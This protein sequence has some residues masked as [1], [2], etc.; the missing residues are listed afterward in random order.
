MNT[1]QWIQIILSGSMV[2]V[3]IILAI[4]TGVLALITYGYMKATKKMAESMRIQSKIMQ[5]EFELK[6]APIFEPKISVGSTQGLKSEIKVRLDNFGSYPIIFERVFYKLWHKDFPHDRINDVRQYYKQIEKGNTFE[7]T[8][9]V[10]FSKVKGFGN[11]QNIGK[12]GLASVVFT[13]KDISG[14]EI[15]KFEDKILLFH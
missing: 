7:D 9:Q 2:F 5:R 10:D 4:A 1:A 15:K 8:I 11:L 3:T 14:N 12:N 13:L 6:I